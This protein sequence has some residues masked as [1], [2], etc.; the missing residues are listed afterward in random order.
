[1]DRQIIYTIGHSTHSADYFL[2]LLQTYKVNC[3]VDVRSVAASA[4]NPQYNKEPFSNFLKNNGV[5][6]IHLPEEF[7]ARHTDPDLLDDDDKVDFEKVRK[8]WNF[9][10][11]VERL[12]KEINKGLTIALMCS[13]SEPFDCHRFSMISIALEKDGFDVQHIL[14]DKTLKSNSQLESQ[15][16][17]KYEKKIPKPDMF[18]PNVTLEVQLQAAY[19]LRNKEIAFSPYTKEPE[20]KYD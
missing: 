16:L 20:E 18:E 2:E 5:T 19:R 3:V 11:G 17:K 14:K 4:Y 15:L 10:N 6:Y 13:E 9:Q 8:S 12:W 1:M 7:G